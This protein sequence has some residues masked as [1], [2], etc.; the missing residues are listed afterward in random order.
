MVEILGRVEDWFAEYQTVGLNTETVVKVGTLV[1]G[2]Y[3]SQWVM[4]QA[5]KYIDWFKT[6]DPVL[7]KAVLG[8]GLILIANWIGGQFSPTI[9][10]ILKLLGVGCLVSA[11]YTWLFAKYP[12]A[13]TLVPSEVKKPKE[14][15]FLL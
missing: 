11:G 15:Q 5:K 10:G 9:S 14:Q 13:G 1:G 12:I 6:A 3:G 4:E 8:L 7:S 2:I